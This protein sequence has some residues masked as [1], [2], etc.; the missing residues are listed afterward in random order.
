[1]TFITHDQVRARV[2]QGF[3]YTYKYTLG[4]IKNKTDSIKNKQNIPNKENKHSESI[5]I[6]TKSPT[7][8]IF[9]QNSSTRTKLN[10]DF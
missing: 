3:V 1:M 9:H 10:F 6:N 8:G 5:A 7:G 2:D 4:N